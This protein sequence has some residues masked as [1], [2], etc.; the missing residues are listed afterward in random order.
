MYRILL[1]TIFTVFGMSSFGQMYY[2]PIVNYSTHDY[3]KEFN[4]ENYCLVQDQRGIMYFGT[5]N[6][7]HEFDG[8][9]WNYIEVVLGTFV[10]SM[11]VDSTGIIY[12]GTYG[13]FGFLQ[14]NKIGQLEYISLSENLPEEDRFFSDIWSIYTTKNK[15]YFQAQE[16]FFEYNLSTSEITVVYPEEFSSF[17]TAFILDGVLHLRARELGIVKYEDGDLKRLKGTEFV[18]NLGVFGLHKLPDDSLLIITQE[19]GLWKWKN[20]AARQLPEVNKTP[21]TEIGIYG[22]T[23][24]VDG[25]FALRTNTNGAKIINSKGKIV[26]SIDR[27]IGLRSND[28]KDVFEDRDHNL[29]L[30]LGNGIAKVNYFSPLSYFNELS[31]IEGNVEAMIRYKGRLYVGTSYGLFY[32][33]LENIYTKEFVNS[34][35]LKDQ[36]WDF[37]IVNN[38]LYIA[39]SKGVYKTSGTNF[40]LLTSNR[41]NVI[42]YIADKNIFVSAGSSG[43]F[44]YNVNFGV[45]WKDEGGLRALSAVED[46]NYKNTL[47]IGTTMGV[48]RLQYT[49]NGFKFDEFGMFDGLNDDERTAPI[50]FN[51]SIVF[52]TSEGLLTFIHEDE[53]IK[54]LPDSLKDDPDYYRGM[55]QITTLYDSLFTSQLLLIEEDEDKTWYCSDDKIGYYDQ[56]EDKFVNKPFWGIDYGRVNK[57]YLEENGVLWIGCADGLIRYEKNQ[58]KVYESKFYSLIRKF[59]VNQDSILFSGAFSKDGVMKIKQTEAYKF[60]IDY[61]FNNV[62]FVFASPYFEDEHVPEFSFLLEGHDEQWSPWG[63]VTEATFTN[64]FEGDYNFRVRARNVYGTLS[65]EASFKFTILPPW[66]RTSWAFI[67]YGLMFIVIFIVGFRIFSLRLKRKNQWLEGV[68]EERTR[69][70]SDKNKVLR[71]QQQEIQDSINYAQR[72]QQAILPLEDEMKKYLPKSF[73]LFRPKDVVSGDFYWFTHK[74]G[75]KMVL[76]CADCTGHGVPGA[77]MSMIGSDRLNII[78]GERKLIHPGDILSELNRAIKKSL[79]QDGQ[80]GSSRDGMD[81]AVCTIDMKT[82]ELRYAGANRPLWIVKDGELEEVKATKVAV[83]GFT[84]DDQIFEEHKITIEEGMK[85]YMTSDGYADQFGGDRGKKLKV[86]TMK[87]F[88]LEICNKQYSDQREDLEEYLLEWMGDHEQIDDV[89]VIGFEPVY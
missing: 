60:V 29:W 21:L 71:H 67:L 35:L 76:I 66:Y 86:K 39:T 32:Q 37:E 41:S 34:L 47:W 3:G 13:D 83:A 51:D 16:Q 46:P 53:M 25:N 11:A 56:K 63:T 70:I 73:V 62:H 87:E 15:V 54:D 77:F 84:P 2:P 12:V 4:P 42:K 22:S 74:A 85:F 48:K 59:S 8:K 68:V 75:D 7:V 1:L 79:K 38:V 30:T 72:I 10:R 40:Q 20:N 33:D 19:I 17:H 9:R 78:V 14:P 44:V 61:D 82:K 27:S 43:V 58:Q 31:G 69:E 89:C 6:G 80:T 55:F 57:F 65:E 49:D 88:I 23:A 18:R 45:L 52:G 36:V 81:A 5:G 24:L 50:L 26:K 28:V 64:L